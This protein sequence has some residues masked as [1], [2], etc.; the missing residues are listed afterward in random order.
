MPGVSDVPSADELAALPAGELAA[1]LAEAYRLIGELTA[2]MEEL[3]TQNERLAARVE[4][5]ERQARRLVH[6]VAAPVVGQS[7]SE[8]EQGPVAA[9]AGEAPPGQA[10]G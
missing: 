3:F 6:V 7:V 4:D 1:R 2:R 9:G 10:A 5:L 8:E